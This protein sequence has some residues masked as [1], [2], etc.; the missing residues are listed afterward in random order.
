MFKDTQVVNAGT[1]GIRSGLR[2]IFFNVKLQ[3]LLFMTGQDEYKMGSENPLFQ[4]S[5]LQKLQWQPFLGLLPNI[6]TQNQILC[7]GDF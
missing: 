2:D 7:P 3:V 4:E 5:C 1:L 6:F